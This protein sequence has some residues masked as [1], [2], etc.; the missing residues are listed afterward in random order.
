MVRGPIPTGKRISADLPTIVRPA[1]RLRDNATGGDNFRFVTGSE[2]CMDMRKLTWAVA[3]AVLPMTVALADDE[4]AASIA[5]LKQSLP[6]DQG[7]EVDEV[8]VTQSGVACIDY[9]LSNEKGA[10]S[11]AHAVVQGDEVLQSTS[12]NSRFEK[13]WQDHCLGPRGGT[14]APGDTSRRPFEVA[15]TSPID[16]TAHA[17]II[18]GSEVMSRLARYRASRVALPAMNCAVTAAAHNIAVITAV[19]CDAGTFI[20]FG[21]RR[22]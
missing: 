16:T 5:A 7:F 19:R 8:R 14:K 18:A 10:Q 20:P 3:A 9:R 1:R 13:A 15:T 21:W 12:G 6:N 11:P 2:G 17:V 4:T 22:S